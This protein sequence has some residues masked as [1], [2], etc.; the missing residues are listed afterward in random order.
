MRATSIANLTIT[1]P[2]FTPKE[3]R[4]VFERL[5][6]RFI[7]D[8]RDLPFVWLSLRMTFV[9]MPFAAYLY[10]PGNFR[11]WLGVIYIAI[12]LAFFFGRYILMLHNT[13]HKPLFKR[14]YKWMNNYIPWV[15]GPFAGESPETYY[16]HHIAMHHAEGNLP[17]DLSSTMKYQRDSV[18][19]F[20]KYFGD[21]FLFTLFKLA[22]YHAQKNRSRIVRM[23]IVGELSLYTLMGVGLWLNWRATFVVFVFPFILC[24]FMM[25]CGNWAQ[26]SFIDA[27]DPGNSYKNSITCINSG[28]N[29][30]C[31]NDG[32]H[33]GHHVLASRH[34]TEMPADFEAQREKY[35]AADAVV[36][37]KLDYF[38]IWMLL[39]SKSYRTLA[40]NFVDLRDEPRTL[41]EI[42][43]LLRSRTQRIDVTDPLVLA[44]TVA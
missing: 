13:S 1:D 20:L 10:W 44:A 40:K 41:D 21:F 22:N 12:L 16:A 35:V 25:M 5:A 3:A 14:K 30:F 26:H 15:L 36:F 8:E 28:Y 23:V 31:F 43:A 24:R 6:L 27:R 11:W 42:E 19:D 4:N 33:I 7:N 37:Q 29:H 32:Y 18:I 39:M 38:F 2:R 17:K 34:W 9:L